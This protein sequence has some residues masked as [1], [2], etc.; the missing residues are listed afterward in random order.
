MALA[1]MPT[2]HT[3]YHKSLLRDN[4][5]A[6]FLRQIGNNL[7]GLDSAITQVINK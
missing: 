4:D 6:V 1:I 2:S 7:R 3:D 5:R